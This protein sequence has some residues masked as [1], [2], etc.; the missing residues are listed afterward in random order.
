M[1][2]E[3]LEINRTHSGIQALMFREEIQQLHRYR[4]YSFT[5]GQNPGKVS[6]GEVIAGVGFFPIWLCVISDAAVQPC[7]GQDAEPHACPY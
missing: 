1:C 4:G 5:A 7:R 2:A 3:P 6:L